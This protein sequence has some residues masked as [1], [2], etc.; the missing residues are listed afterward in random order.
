MKEVSWTGLGGKRFGWPGE[1]NPWE[2]TE[3]E[4]PSWFD[5]RVGD[6]HIV[7]RLVSSDNIAAADV[8]W[9]KVFSRK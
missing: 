2:K 3:K 4:A 9:A 7:E 5:W 8:V 1:S 6:C